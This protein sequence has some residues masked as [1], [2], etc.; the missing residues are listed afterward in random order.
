MPE[1]ILVKFRQKG[2]GV[3]FDFN[4]IPNGDIGNSVQSVAL[5]SLFPG[6]QTG[7][8]IVRKVTPVNPAAVFIPVLVFGPSVEL[9]VD[10]SPEFV[11][12]A[13]SAD[14]LVIIRPPSD[15]RVHESD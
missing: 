8:M 6:S 3:G 9:P 13:L 10:E 5:N 1:K 7:K 11:E 2:V 12:S 4:M 14:S 15:H